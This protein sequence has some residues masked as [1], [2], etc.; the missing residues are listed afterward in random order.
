MKQHH[1]HP[2]MLICMSLNCKYITFFII[3]VILIQ[4][5]KNAHS[6]KSNV[7]V[8]KNVSEH[9]NICFLSLKVMLELWNH[10]LIFS[11]ILMC[12]TVCSVSMPRRD[13]KA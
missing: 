4:K 2:C 10:N 3:Q 7:R 5:W 13:S 12:K 9:T 6:V 11:V 1:L 8:H